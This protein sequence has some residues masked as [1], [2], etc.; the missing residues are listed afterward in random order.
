MTECLKKH[1]PRQNNF[2]GKMDMRRHRSIG[3]YQVYANILKVPGDST[4][5]KLQSLSPDYYRKL[6]HQYRIY[7]AELF[8]IENR[9]RN[10]CGV[11]EK[12][13]LTKNRSVL[14]IREYLSHMKMWVN[15]VIK[16]IPWF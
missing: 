16:K 12:L 9:L 8:K 3:V 13:M 7:T 14:P 4:P 15:Q 1:F 2:T 6:N 10:D 11:D 5:R